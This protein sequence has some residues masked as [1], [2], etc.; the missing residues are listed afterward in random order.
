MV[1]R[2]D[3][4]IM[5]LISS[6]GGRDIDFTLVCTYF[7]CQKSEANNEC[8]TMLFKNLLTYI[9]REE[10]QQQEEQNPSHDGIPDHVVLDVLPRGIDLSCSGIASVL[11]VIVGHERWSD[12]VR[13]SRAHYVEALADGR[14]EDPLALWEP[15]GGQGGR[16]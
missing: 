13:H 8:R 12:Q 5:L 7:K 10:G 6:D 2:M 16:G 11:I 14:G 15:R 4:F 3:T 1:L 9:R